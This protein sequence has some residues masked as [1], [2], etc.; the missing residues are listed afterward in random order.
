MRRKMVKKKTVKA[1]KEVYAKDAQDICVERISECQTVLDH[2]ETCPAWVVIR[3][4]L[5]KNKEYNDNNWW[6]LPEG[7]K[8]LQE[9]RI[10]ALAYMHLLGITDGYQM[11]LDNARK[12]LDKLRN[13]DKKIVKDYDPN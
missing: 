2:L 5:I 13:T 8:D 9:L 6:K 3:K 7:S 1:Q 11:D 4:D 10:T 12:E